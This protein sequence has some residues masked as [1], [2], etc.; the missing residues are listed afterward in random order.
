MLY[1]EEFLRQSHI[2]NRRFGLIGAEILRPGARV[3]IL[4]GNR[5]HTWWTGLWGRCK[6]KYFQQTEFLFVYFSYQIIV[7]NIGLNKTFLD[8]RFWVVQPRI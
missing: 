8:T 4:G 2:R 5:L 7:F 6:H 3:Q 1:I